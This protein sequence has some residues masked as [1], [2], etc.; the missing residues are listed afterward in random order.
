MNPHLSQTQ[1][2][3]LQH[4]VGQFSDVF[5]PLPGQ[6]NVIQH[7]IRTPPKMI[8]RQRPYRVPEA[9]WQA[10]EEEVQQM[11]KLGVIE[12]SRSP[13]SSPIVM[14]PKPDGTL[15][16]CND[17]RQLSE[18]SEFDGYPMP[19]GYW[20][21]PLAEE[22][23]PKTAFT[24]SSGH[25]Q[26]RTLPFG[27]HGAPATF[28]RLMDIILRPYQ[29]YTAAYIDDVV[30]HS[31]HWDEHLSHLRRVL[32]ELRWAGLTTNPRKCHL[33]LSEAK[34]LGYQVGRGLI[35]P[36]PKKVEAVQAAPRRSTKTQVQAFLGLA[37]YYRCFIPNFSSLASP[38]TDL[39][40]KGQPEKIEWSPEAEVAFQRVKEA[41]MSGTHPASP[42]LQLPLPGANGRLGHRTR[43]SPVPS[44]G[45]RGTP[46]DNANADGLSRIWSAFAV[47]YFF[48]RYTK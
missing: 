20:Q 31:E 15:R 10:I 5:S 19:Q 16:F 41:L 35:K 14:V 27:L 12:P 43:C 11:L 45:R 6:A 37:G 21:V 13:W 36:Q 23:K 2:T 46:S 47:V 34:Y 42:G 1:K 44:K 33:A 28:Q 48:T 29:A 39:T 40:R 30:I 8:D 3:E 9:H 32:T 4:L 17:F 38:L 24:T 7:E 18:V 26:Y 22:A 25:W